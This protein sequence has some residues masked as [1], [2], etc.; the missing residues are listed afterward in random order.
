M[1]VCNLVVATSF[2]DFFIQLIFPAMR[3]SVHK[4]VL[5]SVEVKLVIVCLDINWMWT[6]SIVQV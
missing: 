5:T 4:V 1:Y 6:M 3:V 2:I